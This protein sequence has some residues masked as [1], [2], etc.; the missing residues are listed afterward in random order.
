MQLF[1]NSR[2]FSLEPFSSITGLHYLDLTC[3]LSLFVFT[4]AVG[5]KL[6]SYLPL[7]TAQSSRRDINEKTQH[8]NATYLTVG[9]KQGAKIRNNKGKINHHTPLVS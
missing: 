1:K 9:K 2:F 6:L 4:I 7:F 3:L 8:L 5:Q